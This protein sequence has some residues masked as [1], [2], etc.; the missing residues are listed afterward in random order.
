MENLQQGVCAF[1]QQLL[2]GLF[3]WPNATNIFFV[4]ICE[5]QDVR[6]TSN[7]NLGVVKAHSLGNRGDPTKYAK[8]NNVFS[9]Q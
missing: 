1:G 7:S 3:T 9:S 2:H 8:G 4:G 6:E 5:K